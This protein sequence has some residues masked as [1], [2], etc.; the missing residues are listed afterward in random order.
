MLRYKMEEDTNHPDDTYL[1]FLKD[2]GEEWTDEYKEKI[3]NLVDTVGLEEDSDGGEMSFL[4][5]TDDQ[6]TV[7]NIMK[8]NDIEEEL[9]EEFDYSHLVDELLC[10]NNDSGAGCGCGKQCDDDCDKDSSEQG[11]GCGGSCGSK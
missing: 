1:T 2:D 5:C 10:N 9:E 3:E 6:L 8:L 11:C 4:M 7:R